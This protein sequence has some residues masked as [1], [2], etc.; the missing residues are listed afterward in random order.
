MPIK[1]VANHNYNAVKKRMSSS[2]RSSSG[3][4]FIPLDKPTLNCSNVAFALGSSYWHGWLVNKR[5]DDNNIMCDTPYIL[6]KKYI[7]KKIFCYLKYR[8]G[9]K[10]SFYNQQCTVLFYPKDFTSQKRFQF[11]LFTYFFY[12]KV[13]FS[14]FF[15]A[16]LEFIGPQYKPS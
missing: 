2:T 16:D 4:S 1:E 11:S 10:C 15:C 13:R 3:E 6:F 8:I 12:E 5:P 14:C 7:N 9:A